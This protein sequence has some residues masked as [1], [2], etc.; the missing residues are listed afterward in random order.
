MSQGRNG[1]HHCPGMS[2]GRNGEFHLT[3]IC[4][5]E[6]AGNSGEGFI[7]GPYL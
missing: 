4:H 6:I 1:G 7:G 2:Q 3:L 5:T